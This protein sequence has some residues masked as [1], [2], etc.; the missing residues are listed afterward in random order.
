MKTKIACLWVIPA[1]ALVLAGCGQKEE[2]AAATPK[3]QAEAKP[4]PAT[5]STPNTPVSPVVTPAA[6]PAVTQMVNEAMAPAPTNALAAEALPPVLAEPVDPV[7][8]AQKTIDNV[9]GFVERKLYTVALGNMRGL[10]VF[11]LTPEQEK[12]VEEIKA[13][14]KKGMGEEAYEAAVKAMGG[15][16]KSKE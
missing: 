6:A 15:F 14:I 11:K 3:S 9:K 7:I 5:D 8:Q 12:A 10:A 1:V 13:D 16:P 2:P 4:A